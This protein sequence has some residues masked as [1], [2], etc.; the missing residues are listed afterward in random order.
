LLIAHIVNL[1][2][3]QGPIDASAADHASDY[4]AGL[5]GVLMSGTPA[6]KS[7]MT[8]RAL[9][10]ARLAAVRAVMRRRFREPGLGAEAVG[11]SLGLSARYVQHLLQ[12]EGSTFSGELMELRLSAARGALLA[13]PRDSITDI[14]F[15][16]GFADL[17]TFYRSFRRRF[18]DTPNAVR[19]AVGIP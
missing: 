11:A 3:I 7:E 8:L 6:T 16:C 1:L 9:P 17:S 4:L 15:R 14:A 18:G 5:V 2:A 13:S 12:Q 19:S 10:K